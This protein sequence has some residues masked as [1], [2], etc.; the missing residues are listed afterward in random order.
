[1]FLRE[2]RRGGGRDRKVEKGEDEE[3]ERKERKKEPIKLLPSREQ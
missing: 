2:R 1:M 3:W